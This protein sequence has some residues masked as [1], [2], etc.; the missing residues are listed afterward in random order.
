MAFYAVYNIISKIVFRYRYKIISKLNS[1]LFTK[2][3]MLKNSDNACDKA[4]FVNFLDDSELLD[5]GSAFN[6]CLSLDTC[7]LIKNNT[8][9]ILMLSGSIQFSILL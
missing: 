8:L 3:V 7:A 9:S 6:H 2:Y 5:L 1:F 4:Y